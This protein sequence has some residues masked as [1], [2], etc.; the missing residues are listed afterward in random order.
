MDVSGQCVV[1]GCECGC[2][3]SRHL[4]IEYVSCSRTRGRLISTADMDNWDA[5]FDVNVKGT[6][7][8]FKQAAKQMIGQGRG[9]RLIG[10]SSVLGKMGMNSMAG[11]DGLLNGRRARQ[12]D[13]VRVIQVCCAWH[14][15]KCR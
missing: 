10:A 4:V 7:L 15:S 13:C 2:V 6:F 14:C 12:S 5:N 8:C 3:P 1:D 9:G 11:G